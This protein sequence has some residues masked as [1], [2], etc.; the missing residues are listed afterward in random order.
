MRK[1][2]SRRL[3]ARLERRTPKPLVGIE[4]QILLNLAARS[5]HTKGKTIWHLPPER[6]LLEYALFTKE[7]MRRCVAEPGSLYGNAFR[8]GQRLRRISGF[9]DGEDLERLVFYLYRNLQIAMSG[10]LPGTLKVCDCYFSAF[11]TPEQC[12]L[13]SHM[14]SGVIAGLYGGGRLAF[15]LRITE[16][17]AEC[18]AEFTNG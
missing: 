7:S 9:T 12:A 10:R 3:L 2:I 4:L 14:D 5:F 16:G 18:R 17:C 11:Y 1:Q 13:M 8:V 6:A 15:S